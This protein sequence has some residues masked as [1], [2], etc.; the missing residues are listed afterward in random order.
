MRLSL[1]VIIS[2]LLSNFK[3]K[4]NKLHQEDLTQQKNNTIIGTFQKLTIIIVDNITDQNAKIIKW[5]NNKKNKKLVVPETIDKSSQVIGESLKILSEVSFVSP[6]LA[7]SLT[8]ADKYLDV[9]K[10]RLSQVRKDL[11]SN[12][13]KKV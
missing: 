2:S 13:K 9:L 7:D 4:I 6:Y 11:S 10:K 1:F 3:I 5:V 8:D 12:S